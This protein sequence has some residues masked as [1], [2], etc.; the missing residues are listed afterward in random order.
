VRSP[1]SWRR[2]APRNVP[3]LRTSI[4]ELAPVSV[5]TDL[6][7]SN[8]GITDLESLRNLVFVDSG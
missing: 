1:P 6:A 2:K 5:M 7:L 3:I 8:L 4:E